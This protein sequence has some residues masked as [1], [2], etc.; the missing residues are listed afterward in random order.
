M[1]SVLN[2]RSDD[3]YLATESA[4]NLQMEL[5]GT[6]LNKILTAMSRPTR[7]TRDKEIDIN[8]KTELFE[9]EIESELYEAFKLAKSKVMSYLK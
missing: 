6:R 4:E 1:R 2:E 5:K 7:L 9:K 3:P 8:V